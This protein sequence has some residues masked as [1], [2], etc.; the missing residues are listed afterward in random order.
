MS[1]LTTV[2]PIVLLIVGLIV[3]FFGY[4]LLRLSILAR[5]AMSSQQ[6]SRIVRTIDISLPAARR[7][8]LRHGHVVRKW[9]IQA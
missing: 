5:P 1:L 9:P 7:R 6:H 8:H 4:R 3:C 2:S